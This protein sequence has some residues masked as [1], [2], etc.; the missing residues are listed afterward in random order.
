MVRLVFCLWLA[1]GG[2]AL[3]QRQATSKPEPAFLSAFRLLPLGCKEC[4]YRGFTRTPAATLRRNAVC[5][6]AMPRQR[7]EVKGRGKRPA[8]LPGR[9]FPPREKKQKHHSDR[10]AYKMALPYSSQTQVM[11]HQGK[12]QR[13]QQAHQHASAVRHSE[14][15]EAALLAHLRAPSPVAP[16]YAR[17]P[18]LRARLRSPLKPLKPLDGAHTPFHTPLGVC[19][20]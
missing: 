14:P 20:C 2:V 12:H 16:L 7:E 11:G 9:C 6:L 18:C 13:A 15:L 19:S 8:A 3:S 4:I 10:Y 5:Q 1:V 17:P